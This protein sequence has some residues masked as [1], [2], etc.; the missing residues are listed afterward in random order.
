MH[1]LAPK[2]ARKP[3]II[4]E[5][6]LLHLYMY[7]PV[8]MSVCLAGCGHACMYVCGYS[9]GAA[10]AHDLPAFEKQSTNDITLPESALS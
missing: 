1:E 4:D 7:V 6:R 2:L 3:A 9:C 10:Y 8:C 5:P